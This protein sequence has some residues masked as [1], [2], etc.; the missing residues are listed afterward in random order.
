MLIG[1]RALV[2]VGVL[3]LCATGVAAGTQSSR[4]PLPDA[5]VTLTAGGSN[6]RAGD[7]VRLTI[8]V[9][10]EGAAPMPPAP[11][12]LTADGRQSAEWAFP[13]ELAP[14]ESAEWRTTYVGTR[15]MH[16]LSVS[17]DPLDEVLESSRSNNTAFLNIGLADASPPF[18]WLALL[19]GVLFFALG[20]GAGG[21]LRRP[22]L[23][24]SRPRR[25]AVTRP[26]P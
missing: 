1:R 16:L 19:F 18:P 13:R 11:V 25:K 24:R 23:G 14:G 17:V 22:D 15:G 2:A 6:L 5:A 7:K 4:A 3:G 10:N 8:V 21:L 12:A 20:M 26:R 9:R